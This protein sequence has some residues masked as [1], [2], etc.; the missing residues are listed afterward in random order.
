M[1]FSAL[2]F[3]RIL[4]FLS[5][6]INWVSAGGRAEEVLSYDDEAIGSVVCSRFAAVRQGVVG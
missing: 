4:L 3:S 6:M 5:A 1:G 2:P